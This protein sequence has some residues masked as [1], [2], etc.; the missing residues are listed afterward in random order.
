MSN[1][2]LG[3]TLTS[4]KELFNNSSKVNDMFVATF[5]A[6]DGLSPSTVS[7]IL[8]IIP[9]TLQTGMISVAVSYEFQLGDPTLNNAYILNL[10]LQKSDGEPVQNVALIQ[11]TPV[12][13]SGGTGSGNNDSIQATF[14]IPEPDCVISVGIIPY[15]GVNTDPTALNWT[16]FSYTANIVQFTAVS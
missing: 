2:S 1:A 5:S 9:P 4:V 11:Y 16:E 15:G 6:E 14:I 8:D 12:P 13:I 3:L 10:E 7:N